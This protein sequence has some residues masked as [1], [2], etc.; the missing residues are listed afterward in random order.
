[1]VSV[2]ILYRTGYENIR[3][4]VLESQ[5][6]K[7]YS[8]DLKLNAVLNHLENGYS[9]RKCCDKYNISSPEVLKPLEDIQK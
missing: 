3:P 4:M 8:I 2:K 5:T 7:R 9:L 1:M 6:W